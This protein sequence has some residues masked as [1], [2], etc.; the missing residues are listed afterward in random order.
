MPLCLTF[1]KDFSIYTNYVKNAQ[2]KR[3]QTFRLIDRKIRPKRNITA[4]NITIIAAHG[5]FIIAEINNPA[6]PHTI[7][8]IIDS[9]TI[10]LNRG[11]NISAIICGNVS[12]D[13]NSIIPTSRMVSTIHTATMAVII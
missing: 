7:D 10:I 1:I 5:T 11:A 3:H 9:T 8:I 4:N 6:T 2:Q 12:I 13:I